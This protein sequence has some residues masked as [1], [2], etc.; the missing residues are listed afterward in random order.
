[1]ATRSTVKK[2]VTLQFVKKTAKVNSVVFMAM[3]DTGNAVSF[4]VPND[5]VEALGNPAR[6]TCELVA[7]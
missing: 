2:A 7:Q 6:I 4:Y 3:T 1:M 5:V